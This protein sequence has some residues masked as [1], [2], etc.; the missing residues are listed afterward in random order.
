MEIQEQCDLLKLLIINR[1]ELTIG[2][3]LPFQRGHGAGFGTCCVSSVT[4]HQP[5]KRAQEEEEEVAERASKPLQSQ[6]G[7]VLY[8]D[9]G[10]AQ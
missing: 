2:L 5:V 3:Q 8:V 7:N 1:C 6:K 4:V 9:Q 10:R